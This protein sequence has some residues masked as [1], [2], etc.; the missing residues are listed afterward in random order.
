[1]RG[2]LHRSGREQRAVGGIHRNLVD[3][4]LRGAIV[5]PAVVSRHPPGHRGVADVHDGLADIAH[6]LWADRAALHLPL[7]RHAVA[8]EIDAGVGIDPGDIGVGIDEQDAVLADFPFRRGG[9]RAGLPDQVRIRVPGLPRRG[10]RVDAQRD[11]PRSHQRRSRVA[12]G[13]ERRQA[14]HQHP[15]A[16]A[17]VAPAQLDRMIGADRHAHGGLGAALP[18]QAQRVSETVAPRKIGRR[19]IEETHVAVLPLRIQ[20][21]VRRRVD[22]LH[23][24][25]GAFQV[26][27]HVVGQGMQQGRLVH[28]RLHGI[29]AGLART[30]HRCVIVEDVDPGAERRGVRADGARPR[31]RREI[32][33]KGL[34]V[35]FGVGIA[36][37]SDRDL[38]GSLPRRN[39]HAGGRDLHVIDAGSHRRVVGARSPGKGDLGA[40]GR[41]QGPPDRDVGMTRITL[42][43]GD[44]MGH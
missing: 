10:I 38:P 20:R 26:G 6:V 41:R 32:D 33:P 15:F 39:L 13:R 16:A 30:R 11:F 8:V 37:N 28:D 17:A 44:H 42:V 35:P 5:R 29:I 12:R 24:E 21:A 23:D 31:H 40:R 22:D 7:R 1:M 19:G 36:E 25:L 43:D 2:R 4:E 34:E 9:N 14:L 18:G 3:L 27:E